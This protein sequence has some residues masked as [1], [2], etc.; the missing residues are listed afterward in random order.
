MVFVNA[1][2]SRMVALVIGS[3]YRASSLGMF[4]RMHELGICTVV[5]DGGDSWARE[6]EVAGVVHKVVVVPGI[7]HLRQD[8]EL[9]DAVVDALRAAS[10]G[11]IT[12]AYN[13]YNKYLLLTALVAERLGVVTNSYEAVRRCVFKNETRKCL[14]ANGLEPWK[15]FPCSTT[16]DI[17]QAVGQI[18]FPA[19]L[20]PAKGSASVGVVK[21]LSAEEAVKTFVKQRAE[22]NIQDEVFLLE[23]YIDGPEFGVEIVM[24]H[25]RLLFC[26]VMDADKQS[27]GQFFQGTGRSFPTAH[28]HVVEALISSH[29]GASVHALGLTTGVFDLDVRF[30]PQCGV[31]ILEVNARMGGGSVQRMHQ[32]VYGMDLIELHLQTC[33]G[34]SVEHVADMHPL[35]PSMCY[36]AGWLE[37]PHSGKV[38]GIGI[39]AFA[40]RLRSMFREHPHV[41]EFVPLCDDGDAINGYKVP[42]LPTSLIMVFAKGAEKS[43]A[44]Q[45]L[46]GALCAAE[47]RI[48]DLVEP[49]AP[50]AHQAATSVDAVVTAAVGTA[51]IC[52]AAVLTH[53]LLFEQVMSPKRHN[54]QADFTSIQPLEPLEASAELLP[55]PVPSSACQAPAVVQ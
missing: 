41:L 44:Q 18:A 39:D 53:Q 34:I 2:G 6:M 15:S 24:Q 1:D 13:A 50:L 3:G 10:I 28:G 51:M 17:E 29:C 42:G 23:E 5:V 40:E 30:S 49:D 35:E 20:K 11:N 8:A 36:E 37:S 46:A 4:E 16:Q 31:R 9:A 32:H 12:G 45:H 48:A 43:F 54:A 47:E 55:L 7:G 25:G 26:S 27:Y 33:M 52:T 38:S 19:I 22:R 14:V 21:V